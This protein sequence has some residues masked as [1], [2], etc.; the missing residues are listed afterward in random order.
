MRVLVDFHHHALA[1]SLLLLLEDRF[2]WTVYFPAG[3]DW[4][5]SDTWQ[6][7]KA[8]HGDRV[9]RQYLEGIWEG[10]RPHGTSLVRDDPRYPGRTQRGISY[11]EARETEWDIIISTLPPNDVGL[12]AL[13][14]RCGAAFGVQVGNNH[15]ESDWG[16]ADFI[17]SSSTLPQAG[18]VDP[19]TWGRVVTFQGKPTVI[20]H[21]EFSLDMFRATPVPANDVVASFVNCFPEGPSYPAFLEFARNHPA[22]ADFRVYGATGQ[23]SW[24]AE[25]PYTDE[26]QA[27]DIGP[28]PQ[29]ADAMRGARAIWHSKH[30]SDG[31]GHTVHN[32]FAVGRPVLGFQRY[33]Q[34]KLAGPLWV[35][36]VTSWDIEGVSD[37]DLANLLVDL[38]SPDTGMAERMGQEAAGRFRD[39]VDFDGEA[40]TIREM[41]A[42]LVA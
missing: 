42:D 24:A 13:A 23:P 2:G 4:Y 8:W 41:L 18:L 36:G 37:H 22:L 33:Y 15:Q 5:T 1:E 16:R 9:A 14:E 25:Q 28:V 11:A 27:G 30:W 3:M 38:L 6:F 21:Q 26:F 32:A 35:Q 12:H 29:V 34:D 10:A 17:L 40:D 20:Y 7:E 31:F 19:D 39:L